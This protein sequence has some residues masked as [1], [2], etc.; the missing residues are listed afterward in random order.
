MPPHVSATPPLADRRPVSTTR[1]N[2]TTTDDY[3]WLRADNWQEVMRDP[4]TLPA[5]IR[6]YLEAE[7]A[8]C[9]TTLAP[10][11]DLRKSLVTE[12]AGRL[13]PTDESPPTP[14]GDWAYFRRYAEGAEH[15][16]Y[17]RHLRDNPGAETVL[18]DAEQA[19]AEQ[20]FFHIDGTA[21]SPAHRYFAYSVD[22]SGAEDHVVHILDTKT[23]DLLPERLHH[24]Q[25]SVVWAPDEQRFIYLTIDENHRPSRVWQHTLGDDP[26]DDRMLYEES[27]PAFFVSLEGSEDGRFA[28]VA[29]HGH[30]MTADARLLPLHDRSADLQLVE[31]RVDGLDY[32]VTVS[33]GTLYIRTNADEAI[34]YKVM[35]SSI[36]QPR[37]AYWTDVTPHQ[38]GCVIRHLVAF[39][40]Y[41]VRLER[42]DG[43]PAIVVRQLA[44]GT[45]HTISFDDEP[46]YELSVRPGYEYAS[47]TL[48]FT[49]SS[50]AS[51]ERIFDYDME[52]R[53]RTLIKESRIPS[54]HNAAD[55]VVKRMFATASD[56]ARVPV[57]MLMR[58]DRQNAGPGPLLL[59][60][61][62]AY[63]T[64]I[65]AAFSPH[66]FS[67][68]DRGF[69][70]AIA[71]VRGGAARGYH[72][73]FNGKLEHKPNTFSDFIAVAEHLCD[74]GICQPGNIAAL[75]R[76]A[77]GMLMGAVANMRPD[78]FR[79]IA[80]EVPFVDVLN[81]M[82]DDSLPLTPPEWTEW[83]NPL[84][85]P[86]AYTRMKA[87]SPYDNITAQAYPH[88]LATGGISDPRVTYWEP[89][90]WV[91]RLRARSTSPAAT[92]LLW[93]NMQAG[94]AGA[95]GRYQRLDEYALTFAFFLKA[96]DM[97]THTRAED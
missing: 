76:S 18:L 50:L 55:Y 32:S 88:I 95:S 48:R 16:C 22:T 9:E 8:W 67:L 83:G 77:G 70:W 75:G 68:V 71:H 52:S 60:G 24:A 89:A 74:V 94:H 2:D 58:R 53:S 63:G 41:L 40:D 15:P 37:R 81:T 91:A 59:Y 44:D 28:I 69:A 6:H 31:P 96:F 4:A 42:R 93:I 51:P 7:N 43:L 25:G 72:W 54:G 73:Y 97:V 33:G 14:H 79:A 13:D 29:T 19:A 36:D 86:A 87:Y 92:L 12:L 56:G 45:E 66:R 21:H 85:D 65:P 35:A 20:A 23:G 64:V 84:E 39:R 82:C 80:A 78:L 1:H 90:K 38:A 62:G 17:V 47:T 46:A 26:A 10:V 57:S 61:Y 34:D 3:A 5:D 30:G 11:A 27:D 49:Y